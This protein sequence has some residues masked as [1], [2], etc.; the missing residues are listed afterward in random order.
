MKKFLFWGLIINSVAEILLY[1]AKSIEFF[2]SNVSIVELVYILNP[3]SFYYLSLRADES[4]VTLILS[5][6]AISAISLTYILIVG[7]LFKVRQQYKVTT[8][9]AWML[10]AVYLFMGLWISKSL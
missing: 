9:V 6:L 3:F 7:I 8:I 4:R 10:V 5:H 2:R 1:A